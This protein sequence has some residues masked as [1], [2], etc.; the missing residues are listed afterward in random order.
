MQCRWN[1]IAMSLSGIVAASITGCQTS[2]KVTF[3]PREVAVANP[4]PLRTGPLA[5]DF[6]SGASYAKVGSH[7]FT[8][9]G[10]PILDVKTN[11]TVAEQVEVAICETLKSAGYD[12]VPVTN[13]HGLIMKGKLLH[14]HFWNYTWLY[15]ILIMGGS[16]ELQLSL[17]DENDRV[18]WIRHF[19]GSS[20]FP[21]LL[22][23]GGFETMIRFALDKVLDDIAREC[24]TAEFQRV[25]GGG[26]P[27]ALSSTSGTR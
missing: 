14:L 26:A 21:N 1:L 18:V 23:G 10:I 20:G 22:F 3:T 4:V 6:R 13:G 17:H 11:Q 12:P 25:L 9:F 5:Q 2:T 15:P 24:R 27:A 16:V 8:V 7:L 19:E